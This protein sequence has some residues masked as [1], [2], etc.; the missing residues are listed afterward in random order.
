MDWKRTATGNWITS[1]GKWSIRGPIFGKPM[2]WL[3]DAV[4]HNR[5][6]PTGKY[7]DCVSFTS[8]KS[9]KRFVEGVHSNIKLQRRPPMRKIKIYGQLVRHSPDTAFLANVIWHQ[10]SNPARKLRGLLALIQAG[11]DVRPAPMSLEF[12][13]VDGTQHLI[14]FLD[15]GEQYA[16]EF[17]ARLLQLSVA[18][19]AVRMAGSPQPVVSHLDHVDADEDW[20]NGKL[21]EEPTRYEQRMAE[22]LGTTVEQLRREQAEAE[23]DVANADADVDDIDL[24]GRGG[25]RYGSL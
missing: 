4:H 12:I 14:S 15:R 13:Q 5:Y 18:A 2:Y 3:Y 11:I 25:D 19:R 22:R 20:A 16:A 23:A 1:D 8:L 24:S 17:Q 6:T 9:A 10:H 21:A 7:D